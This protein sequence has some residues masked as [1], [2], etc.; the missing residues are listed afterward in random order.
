MNYEVGDRI[1]TK[2]GEGTVERIVE[3]QGYAVTLDKHGY[4]VAIWYDDILEELTPQRSYEET[5]SAYDV[6][7]HEFLEKK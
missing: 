1:N 7:K 3:N 4:M 6:L 5:Q 2:F